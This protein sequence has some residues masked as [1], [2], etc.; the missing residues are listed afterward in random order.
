MWSLH[1]FVREL[2]ELSLCGIYV[3]VDG[4][5]MYNWERRQE[6]WREVEGMRGNARVFVVRD[7]IK[8]NVAGG[9][10]LEWFVCFVWGFT[11]TTNMSPV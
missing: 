8:R 7:A 9:L 1:Q 11:T 3:R 4:H 10:V 5:G 6:D 2:V